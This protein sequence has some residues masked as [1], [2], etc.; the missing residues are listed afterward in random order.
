MFCGTF[1]GRNDYIVDACYCTCAIS[2]LENHRRKETPGNGWNRRVNGK[3]KIIKEIYIGSLEKLARIIENHFDNMDVY[4]LSSR[5]TVSVMMIETII[6]F[7]DIIDKAGYRNS[8]FSPDNYV[9]TFITN[10]LSDPRSKKSIRKWMR[11][12]FASTIYHPVTAKS[13][14]GI[15]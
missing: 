8:G 15:T 5:I 7:K 4:P 2:S 10:R 14:S 1:L 9:L 6:D 13:D 11:N 12:D 3:P